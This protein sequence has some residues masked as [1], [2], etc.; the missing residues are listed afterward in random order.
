[1]EGPSTGVDLTVQNELK[2][3]HCFF[4]TSNIKLVNVLN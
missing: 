2:Y 3:D 4:P 1:M